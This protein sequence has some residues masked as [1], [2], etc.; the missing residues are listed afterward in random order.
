MNYAFSQRKINTWMLQ[1]NYRKWPSENVGRAWEVKAEKIWGIWW[2]ANLGNQASLQLVL[3][4]HQQEWK[5]R[6]AGSQ[7]HTAVKVQLQNGSLCDLEWDSVTS[8]KSADGCAGAIT[9]QQITY[10]KEKS[11]TWSRKAK[12]QS[13]AHPS[14][15][16]KGIKGHC[17]ISP[18]K[19]HTNY[20]QAIITPIS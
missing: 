3:W 13:T 18:S 2:K 9:V 8:V 7:L 19:S 20:F 15:H 16:W 5:D 17:F 6:H 4:K 14:D 10:N 11:W 12:G 1:G